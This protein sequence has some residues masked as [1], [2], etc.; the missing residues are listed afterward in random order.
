[1]KKIKRAYNNI[2]EAPFPRRIGALLIDLLATLVIALLTYMVADVAFQATPYGRAADTR[3]YELTS[4]TSLYIN[5]GV[6]QKNF[7][8]EEPIYEGTNESYYLASL[9]YFYLDAK[10]P[11]NDQAIFVYEDSKFYIEDVAFHF[12][13]MV[14]DM[15]KAE[16]NFDFVMDGTIVTSYHFKPN[17]TNQE[18]Q[19][20]W[21]DL[22]NE[23]IGEFENS[24]VYQTAKTPLSYYLFASAAVSLFIGALP[25]FL[26]MPLLLKNG[27]TIGK[28][29]VG[30]ALV[31][32][33]GYQVKT[34]QVVVRYLTLGGLELGASVPLYAIPLF[35]SSAAVTITVG[36]RSFHDFLAKTYVVDARESQI[37]PNEKDE[38]RYFN[39]AATERQKAAIT[40]YQMPPKTRKVYKKA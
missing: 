28:Y 26:I 35:L 17:L 15:N 5:D 34:W 31:S 21:A 38:A 37:F 10:D 3:I 13:I 27:Q 2:V 9:E 39:P 32:D 16:T 36:G 30:L 4:A 11:I 25:P 24:Q 1:M 6:N 19:D 23:A 7:A 8:R 22:Y 12:H 18:K 40:F 29:F 20:V 33:K 14:L